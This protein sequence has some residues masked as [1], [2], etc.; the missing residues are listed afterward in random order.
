MMLDVLSHFD[1]LKVCVAYDLDGQRIDR[2]ASQADVLRRCQPVYE[3]LAGWNQDVTKVRSMKEFPTNARKYMDR[4]SEL[5]S[6]P[7]G[8]VSVGPDREQTIFLM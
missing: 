5:V 8:V 6:V 3:T 7:L 2:L 1:E 4:I